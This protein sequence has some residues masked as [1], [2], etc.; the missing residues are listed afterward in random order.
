[1]SVPGTY[2]GLSA[3][4]AAAAPKVPTQPVAFPRLALPKHLPL[5]LTEESPIHMAS[6]TSP[7]RPKACPPCPLEH[8]SLDC[9]YLPRCIEV[10]GLLRRKMHPHLLGRAIPY[11]RNLRPPHPGRR[12]RMASHGTLHRGTSGAAPLQV[13]QG[14]QVRAV[15]VLAAPA[16]P[17][18]IRNR[19]RLAAHRPHRIRSSSVRRVPIHTPRTQVWESARTTSSRPSKRPLTQPRQGTLSVED[20]SRSVGRAYRQ[21]QRQAPTISEER[22]SSSICATLGR[23]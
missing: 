21:R 6:P 12:N 3:V 11:H 17:S 7:Q 16:R 22:R 8:P 15:S 18:P 23:A 9:K 14:H 4:T 5:V 10:P 20:R 2:R 1:M 13:A 19:V